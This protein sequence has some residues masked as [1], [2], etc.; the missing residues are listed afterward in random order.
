MTAPANERRNAVRARLDELGADAFLATKIVNVRYLTGFTGSNGQ[1]LVGVADDAFF[2]DGRYQEQAFHQTSDVALVPYSSARPLTEALGPALAERRIRRLAVEAH[3]VTLQMARLLRDKLAGVELVETTG[4]VERLRLRKT[5]VE[6][7]A[8]TLAAA[9]GDAAFDALPA[10]LKEGM[11]ESELATELDDAMRRA[12]S[13]GLSFDSIVA[14]GESAAEPHHRPGDRRL[15]RGDLIKLDF[16][17]TSGGYHSDMTR[18]IAF[19]RPGDE[20]KRI[21]R[22]VYDAQRAGVD[23]VHPGIGCSAVDDAARDPVVRSGYD[24]GHGTGHGVGLEVHEAPSVRKESD[25]VLEAG[26]VITVEPGIYLPGVGGVRIEDTLV[27]TSD[28]CSPL[29]RAPHEL[30]EV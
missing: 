27:V 19:G 5:E 21:H 4:V 14:F 29:T 7:D 1:V 6:I 8:L 25:E 10:R 18:T 26:M 20:A 28:G 30:I 11:S 3:H 15:R 12:G 24:F 23:A 9:I 2:T 17:A 13:E 16:G 22:I